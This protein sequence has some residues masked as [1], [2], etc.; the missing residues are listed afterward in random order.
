MLKPNGTLAPSQC[1]A[2]VTQRNVKSESR[3]RASRQQRRDQKLR[4]FEKKLRDKLSR[5]VR[6]RGFFYH[7]FKRTSAKIY[8]TYPPFPESA[9]EHGKF[10]NETFR[11]TGSLVRIPSAERGSR[12]K[13]IYIY[14]AL[15]S[16][17]Y[18]A[19]S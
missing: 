3:G 13:H 5:L 4:E 14:F 1:C 10:R 18:S 15:A 19:L 12:V 17:F 2:I 7:A 11:E 9:R 6:S 16:S 8:T